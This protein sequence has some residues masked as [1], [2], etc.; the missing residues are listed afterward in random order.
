MSSHNVDIA[1]LAEILEEVLRDA[2]SAMDLVS[3]LP[4]PCRERIVAAHATLVYQTRFSPPPPHLV[5]AYIRDLGGA[6]AAAV[7]Q[8]LAAAS[9]SS[10]STTSATSTPTSTAPAPTLAVAE[11]T[12][13]PDPVSSVS[14]DAP[15]VV[16]PEP[17]GPAELPPPVGRQRAP[18]SGGYGRRLR[19]GRCPQRRHGRAGHR[20]RRRAAAR[21]APRRPPVDPA[22]R[23][24]AG[25][26]GARRRRPGADPRR[27]QR[28]DHRGDGHGAGH[29][30]GAYAGQG[31]VVAP[32]NRCHRRARRPWRRTSASRRRRRGCSIAGS[33]WARTALPLCRA[34]PRRRL[35]AGHDAWAP[36]ADPAPDRRRAGG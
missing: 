32:H 24:R 3:A 20:P 19:G 35:P 15:S 12:T 9:S 4:L 23:R 1:V 14:G 11:Q 34:A 8:Q 21:G 5:A 28:R 33:S 10:S 16:E 30:G 31:D 26:R 6:E 13:A 22:R 17:E 36:G 2:A 27:L 18:Q 29:G 25:H 7:I